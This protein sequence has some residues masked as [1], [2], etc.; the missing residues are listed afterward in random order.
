MKSMKFLTVFVVALIGLGVIATEATAVEC[1]RN[2]AAALLF[3]GYKTTT[4]PANLTVMT[5][6]NSGPDTIWIRLVWIDGE[7]CTA[8]DIWKELTGYDTI[9]FLDG[10]AGF[11]PQSEVGFLYVYVCNGYHDLAESNGSGMVDDDPNVL[12]GSE[13]LFDGLNPFTPAVYQVNAVGLNAIGKGA[14]VNG[15]GF[16]ELNGVEYSAAA[17][18]IMFPRFFGQGVANVKSQLML[19][20]LA[21]GAHFDTAQCQVYVY[22]DNEGVASHKQY[23]DCWDAW[24]L[25]AFS[26]ATENTYLEGLGPEGHDP[27][28]PYGFAGVVVAGWISIE[29]QYAE[30]PGTAFITD[31]ALYGVLAEILGAGPNGV[32]S[33]PWQVEGTVY[34]RVG[35]WSENPDG[36]F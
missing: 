3:P 15:D 10:A 4:V 35:L 14:A 11:N 9:T 24:D 13:F 6:T 31:A 26:A 16:L 18:K 1:G 36:S 20:N 5:V 2:P 12:I 25:L 7:Q 32:A 34:D 28:E 27:L 23:F 29:E 22:N 30:N 17:K 8:E 19:I 33:L 21:G